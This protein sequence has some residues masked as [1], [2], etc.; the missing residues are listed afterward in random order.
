[1]ECG[2]PLEDGKDKE[3]NVPKILQK[4]HSS[5][6]ILSLFSE[7]HFGFLNYSSLRQYIRIILSY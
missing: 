4:G 5:T 2:C 1:M 7:T 6:N 3:T